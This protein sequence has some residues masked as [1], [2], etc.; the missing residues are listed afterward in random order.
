MVVDD[1]AVVRGL[2]TRFIEQDPEMRVVASVGNGQRAI[3]A[4]Q[5][6][7]TDV[8]VLDIEMPVMDGLTALPKLLRAQPGV[9]VIMAS[10]LTKANADVSIRA[11]NAGAADYVAKPS[12]GGLHSKADFQEEL[13]S[14]VKALGAARRKAAGSP[15]LA[16]ARDVRSR[17][18]VNVSKP[19]PVVASAGKATVRRAPP[20][21]P[22][23][24][25]AIGSS[26]GGPQALFQL[27]GGLDPVSQPILITQH[28]P[29]TFTALLAEHIARQTSMPCSEAKDGE[30]LVGG[31]IYV[32]PGGHHMLAERRG[33]GLYLRLSDA[34]PEN[35]CRPSVDPMLR[36]LVDVYG[37]RILAV[38]LTGMGSD[39]CKGCGIVVEAG[40]HVIAQDEET[41]VVWGMPGAVTRAG[42]V[43][44]VLPLAEIAPKIRK[45]AVRSAA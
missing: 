35:F 22:P 45:I 38:I 26:T 28:M 10:T 25:I 42:L 11:L 1:S 29:A 24:V 8:V 21:L 7:E 43:S 32:A 34:P 37:S 4:L 9:Q 15:P 19:K 31:K 33:G 41:S 13:R 16:S 5:R 27:L 14:K 3:E 23:Q 18:G 44:A 39:G 36:S 20:D 30:P 6:H 12:T 17:P 2:V 40:G